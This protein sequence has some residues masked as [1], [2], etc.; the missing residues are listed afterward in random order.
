MSITNMQYCERD[1]V[2]LLPSW[3]CW[4]INVG[5]WLAHQ[6]ADSGRVVV[7]ISAPTR[8][9]AAALLTFGLIRGRATVSFDDTAEHILRMRNLPKGSPVA[10]RGGK[11]RYTGEYVGI[12]IKNDVEK[13]GIKL[14]GKGNDTWWYPINEAIKFES[15]ESSVSCSGKKIRARNTPTSAFFESCCDSNSSIIESLTSRSIQECVIVGQHNLL[16]QE[17]DESLFAYNN[18]LGKLQEIIRIKDDLNP[19]EACHSAICSANKSPETEEYGLLHA[20]IFDGARGYLRLRDRWPAVHHVVILDC[21]DAEFP[22]AINELNRCY[23]YRIGDAEFKDFPAPPR[24][25]SVMVYRR[26]EQ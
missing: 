15:I 11:K 1:K 8:A 25:L 18:E 22:D 3:A 14:G 16:H 5:S 7:A 24:E 9:Y 6:I 2:Y 17:I 12:E 10:Y 19:G 23:Y 21:I 4:F 13:L 20:V 26:E